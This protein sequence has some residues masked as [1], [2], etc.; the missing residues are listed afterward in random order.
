MLKF[1]QTLVSSFFCAT[2][3]ICCI[4]KEHKNN[5]QKYKSV[6]GLYQT[7]PKNKPIVGL[8]TP[9]PIEIISVKIWDVIPPLLTSFFYTKACK[10]INTM[11]PSLYIWE[12]WNLIFLPLSFILCYLDRIENQEKQKKISLNLFHL[13]WRNNCISC[14]AV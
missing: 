14:P 8:R 1:D 9:I 11:I 4:F 5:E 13:F 7:Y 2:S 3:I 6:E 10:L 12:T